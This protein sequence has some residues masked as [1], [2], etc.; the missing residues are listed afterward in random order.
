MILESVENGPLIWPTIEENRVTRTKKYDE[1]SAT[2]TI[3]ANYDLKATNHSLRSIVHQDPYPQPQSVPQI[4]YT[5]FTG[6]QNFYFAG[7]SRTR[8]NT[9]RMGG[10]YLSQQR[11]VKCFNCQGEGHMARQCLKPKRKSDV[12][13]FRDKVLLVEAQGKGKVMNEEE[14]KFLTDPGIAKGPVTQSIVTHN[15]TYQADDLDAYDS[16]CDETST[17][18]TVLMA[19]LSSYGSDVLSE[20]P[21]SDNTHNDMLNQSV[22]MLYDGSVIAKE[23]NVF[24]I[25]DSEE[26]LMLEE[27]SRSKMLLKQSDPMVLEKKV[28][29]KPINYVAL[30]RLSKDL[31]IVNIVVNSS[32]DENTY[33]NVNSF[34]AIHDYVNY[35]EMC[36]KCLE[37]EAELI[38]QHNMVEKDEY[39]RLSKRFSELKQHCISLEIAMQLNNFFQKTNTSV[40]QTEPSFDQLFE[41]NNLRAELQVKDT[42]I[43]E[44]K[45]HIKRVN[46]TSTRESM[47]KD[48]NELETINI[49][50]EHRE[51]VFV[52][53]SL[54]NDLRKLKGKEITDNAAQ[55]SNATIIA[56]IMYK[57]DPVTFAPRDKNNRETHIYYL[58]HTM[59]QADI[60]REIV[61]QVRS[62]NPLNSASYSDVRVNTSTSAS[63]SKPSG[64]TK[65]DR[66]PRTPSSN[67]KN[68]LEVGIS[69]ETSVARTPQQNGVVERQ[70][71]T[72]VE[73]ARTMLIY[74]KALLFLWAEAVATACY[75][76]NRS[77]IQCL[78]GKT[79][80]E[81]LHDRK[82]DLS[83]LYVF[84]ALCYPNNNSE[85]L[86]KLQAKA[87]IGIFIRYAPKKKAYRIY[88]R[89]TQKITKTIHVDFDELTAM[90]SEQ[91]S[92]ELALHEMTPAIPSSGLV[93]NP[94][95]LTPFVPPSRHE[96]DLVFQPVFDEFFSPPASVASP[97]PIEKAPAPFESTGSPSSAT[98]DQDAPSPKTVFEESSSSN[99]IPTT[100]YP[101][102]SISEHLNALTQSCWIEAM[103]EELNEFECLEVWELVPCSYKV[104]VITLKWVYKVKLDELWGGILKNKARLVAC[105]YRQ[106]E[107]IDFEES[108]ASV[109]RR[110]VVQI[111]LA[112]AAH[113]NMIVYQMDVKTIFL[114][115]ILC[116]EVYISQPNRFVDPDNPNHMYRLKKALYGL[117]QATRAWYDLLSSFLL[118]QGF[119]KGT[120]DPTL[121]ISRK[122]KYILLV[123]IYV[124]DIIF[125]STTTELC[126]KFSEIMCSKFKMSMM[127]KISFFLRL[128]ISQSPRGI[129]LS[130]SKYT[131]ESIKKYEMESCNPMDTPMVK[132]SKLYEDKQ[133]KAV[134][135]TH[136]HGMVDT[137]MYLTSSRP[138]LVY[139]VCMCAR[140]QDRPIEKHLHVVKR[141]FRY[142]RGTVNRGLW[143]SKNSA[144][145]LT[146][147]ADA[148]HAGCQDT[149]R[150]TS[151]SMK[152]L[153]DRLVSWS[154]K[155]QKSVAISSMEA[156]YIALSG[157]C[158]Q[159]LWMRS[160][161]SDYGLG[162]NKIPMYYDNK[163]T[164]ALCCN[165]VQRSRSKHIDIRYHFIKEQVENGVVELYFFR[166]EFQLANIFTNAPCRER[167]EFFIDKQGMRS[168]TPET[169]KEL[170]NEAEE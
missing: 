7:A 136:Y 108:F 24:S 25:A 72:L 6:R 134:D 49:E 93:P 120:V 66:I 80:Y 5:V 45:A 100:V 73:T 53:T 33:V 111:F 70:N 1:L 91:S 77:I 145:S 112:S 118:S 142:L 16:D 41:L 63:R 26:T 124:D 152:L 22:P 128:Q 164:I 144:I 132:K 27:E 125:A 47:K 140:Y 159:V 58:K 46:E 165:N 30:N 129:F 60:L 71:C 127:G 62:L 169:L 110:E 131:L 150:S 166:M 126:D 29:I 161:L 162:F 3:Q 89:R 85:N 11:V 113:M 123:Q 160:Q 104:M 88:N 98:V 2:E 99:V 163:S 87:D 12:T 122:G 39:N 151:G 95:P 167:I 69:H 147:F 79:P 84:G 31:D 116:E 86:G 117:K 17:A 158:A 76:Q 148:D 42:T 138:D 153:G 141:I 61:E 157:C 51:K 54:K 34:V 101:D 114:N 36:N 59:E 28:N 68:K 20:V 168:F 67:E 96:W 8:A 92:L 137:L 43:K 121:F 109:A 38:K 81:L 78:H 94:P 56:P 149:R 32:L 57:L 143:Y 103:Q 21:Y 15:A 9:S 50:L 102:A 146:A 133:G 13:W 105:R 40:N 55:V 155:R 97:D 65:N 119:S 48:F 10:S 74:A 18:K 35:V 14:L 139:A 83:Y 154:S 156:E 82:P 106:E 23:T 64:N 107:G 52:I 135:P 170:A 4:E 115:G 19:N 75:T 130:Q 37:L 90:A 44:L